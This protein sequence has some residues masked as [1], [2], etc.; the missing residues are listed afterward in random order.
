MV[1]EDLCSPTN[2]QSSLQQ[3]G[4]RG[5]CMGLL[6]SLT[7][8]LQPEGSAHKDQDSSPLVDTRSL[9]LILLPLDDRFLISHL[10]DFHMQGTVTKYKQNYFM[11]ICL[12]S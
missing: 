11:K 1:A 6:K 8:A 12:S 2:T 4:L 7:S 10:R 5:H 9:K 3:L